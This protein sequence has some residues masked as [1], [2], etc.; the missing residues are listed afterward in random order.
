[1]HFLSQQSLKHVIV[2]RSGIFIQ[3]QAWGKFFL[4]KGQSSLSLRPLVTISDNTQFKDN[5]IKNSHTES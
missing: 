3:I 1:M 2:S 4:E 5:H